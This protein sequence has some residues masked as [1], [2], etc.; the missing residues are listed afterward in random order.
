MGDCIAVKLRTVNLLALLFSLFLT[1]GETSLSSL[2]TT[3]TEY[4]FS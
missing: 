3:G 2:R 1:V 4:K